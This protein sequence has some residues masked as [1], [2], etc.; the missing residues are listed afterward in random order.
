MKMYEIESGPYTCAYLEHTQHSPNPHNVTDVKLCA[1][2]RALGQVYT[3]SS[4]AMVECR[5][6]CSS[7]QG[8]GSFITQ[9]ESEACILS[10]T[11]A[12]P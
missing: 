8:Q 11:Q 9:S 10:Q 4:K 12:D 6:G 5:V 1:F 3:K 7:G 2:L